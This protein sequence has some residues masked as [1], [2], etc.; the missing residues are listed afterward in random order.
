VIAPEES[1]VAE[2]VNGAA[3]S[4]WLGIAVKASV[5]VAASTLKLEVAVAAL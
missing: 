3:P 5:G 1:E 4:V 2:T